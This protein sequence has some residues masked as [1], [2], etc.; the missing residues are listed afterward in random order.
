MF[1]FLL[2]CIMDLYS[3]I[4]LTANATVQGIAIIF[5]NNIVDKKRI[6]PLLVPNIYII[7]EVVN[8]KQNPLKH[9][10]KYTRSSPITVEPISHNN[11]T[12]SMFFS[13]DSFKITNSF[14]SPILF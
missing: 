5:F 9:T 11:T 13:I 14:I 3:F 4:P 8:P 1:S 12:I 7:E 10:I 6:I 2:S